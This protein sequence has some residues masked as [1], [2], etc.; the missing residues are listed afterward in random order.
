MTLFEIACFET[1]VSPGC[2]DRSAKGRPGMRHADEADRRRV[3]WW[4]RLWQPHW[5]NAQIGQV[6]GSAASSVGVALGKPRP[7]AR[8]EPSWGGWEP[9]TPGRVL[10]VVYIRDRPM[11]DKPKTGAERATL[12]NREWSAAV[13]AYVQ[14]RTDEGLMKHG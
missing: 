4:L 12:R 11:P 5:T 10:P 1:R 7:A 13:A 6:T 8:P 9:G 3:W 14:N 2:W